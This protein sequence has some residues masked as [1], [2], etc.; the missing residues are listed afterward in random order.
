MFTVIIVHGLLITQKQHTIIVNKI[1][2][3]YI[4]E[5]HHHEQILI[6][7]KYVWSN[8]IYILIETQEDV[9]ADAFVK[10]NW[11]KVYVLQSKMP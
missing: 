1:V 6:N 2:V 11:E 10:N 8:Y 4:I 7:Q 9:V 5:H 3:C